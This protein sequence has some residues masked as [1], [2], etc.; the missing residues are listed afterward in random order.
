MAW[1]LLWLTYAARRDQ[2]VPCDDVFE[3][4]EW[5]VLQLQS[6]REPTTAAPSLREAIDLVARL[7]GF[8]GRQRDGVPGARVIWRGLS[9][10]GALVAGYRLA[11]QQVVLPN[12][13]G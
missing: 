6:G 12:T 7:G 4:E 3:A 2:E 9:R 13:Y 11:R 5:Q 8:L 1:R 10:L